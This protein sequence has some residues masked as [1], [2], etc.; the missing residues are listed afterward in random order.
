[1]NWLRSCFFQVAFLCVAL[2]SCATFFSKGAADAIYDVRNA[3]VLA[4]PNI[5]AAVL[6]GIGDRVNKAINATV[7]T[8]VY[9]RVVLTIRVLSVQKGSGLRQRAQNVAKVTVDAAFR[10]MTVR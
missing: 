7:R 9:P 10:W 3:V 6:A 5:P 4:G 1:M 8:E 2:T